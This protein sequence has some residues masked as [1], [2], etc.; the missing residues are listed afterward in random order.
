MGTIRSFGRNLATAAERSHLCHYSIALLVIASSHFGCRATGDDHNK[1][2]KQDS[3]DSF[4]ATQSSAEGDEIYNPCPANWLDSEED[5][6]DECFQSLQDNVDMHYPEFTSE[7][8]F[9]PAELE[10]LEQIGLGL[11]GGVTFNPTDNLQISIDGIENPSADGQASC[12]AGNVS[13]SGSVGA[14]VLFSGHFGPVHIV[15]FGA[16]R[17]RHHWVYGDADFSG[18]ARI[19]VGGSVSGNT[20][21]WTVTLNASA[22]GTVTADI[23][24]YQRF[25]RWRRSEWHS[26]ARGQLTAQISLAD[27]V[28]ASQDCSNGG[29]FRLQSPPPPARVSVQLNSFQFYGLIFPNLRG[30]IVSSARSMITRFVYRQ[31]PGM[32]DRAVRSELPKLINQYQAKKGEVLTQLRRKVPNGCGCLPTSTPMPTPTE[33]PP[34]SISQTPVATPT[35]GDTVISPYLPYEQADDAESISM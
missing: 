29:Q 18:R 20:T 22:N 27:S 32:L 30:P 17:W 26:V 2:G 34:P 28:T 14:D 13:A 24:I 3:A 11:T 4:S 35:D 23:H 25:D 7:H 21:R 16:V 33:A 10:E 19:N 9:D 1:K 6:S 12:P 31:A 5:L 15:D 8:S